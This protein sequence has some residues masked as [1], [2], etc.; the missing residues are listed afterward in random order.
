M[1]KQDEF[2]NMIFKQMENHLKTTDTISISKD[3][4][5]KLGENKNIAIKEIKVV[6][7]NFNKS[8]I[9]YIAD[10]WYENN[11]VIVEVS[12]FKENTPILKNES[13]LIKTILNKYIQ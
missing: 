2:L 11:K 1:N 4:E 13:K 12:I 8:D 7:N 6:M 3:L 9:P 5:K 10:M